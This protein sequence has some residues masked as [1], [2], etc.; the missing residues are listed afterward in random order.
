MMSQEHQ[1]LSQLLDLA[2]KVAIITG[3]AMG[4]GRAIALRLVEAG[5]AV[6]IADLDE[7]AASETAEQ[8]TA[9][10]GRA[11]VQRTDVAVVDGTR[12]MVRRTVE[13]FGRLDILVNNA[14][15]FPFAAA[16]A[17][18][19]QQWDHVLDVNLKGA[20]FAAQAAAEQMTAQGDGGRIVNVASVD[21][22]RPTGNLTPYNASKAGLLML[23]K[24]LALEFAP[25]SI[26]VNA[27]V[28]G[29]IMTPGAIKAGAELQQERGV[30]VAEM[31]SAAFLARIPL[32]RLGQ[33]DDVA[34]VVLF[35]ASG[36]ADY[37]TGA[38]VVVDGGY[39]LT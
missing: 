14:G 8:I 23:T 35:L 36:L 18:S 9:R 15:I 34:R 12:E 3:G 29:E 21:A 11:A 25:H 24:A 33:P 2:G 26:L 32:G 10:G 27:V 1:P 7:Q 28:P 22:L 37:I 38:A 30:A 39:L 17:V 5:A 6:M 19:E 31:T 16:R 20:F 4:I 13:T